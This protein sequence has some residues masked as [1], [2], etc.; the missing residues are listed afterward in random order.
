LTF[1]AMDTIQ[2]NTFSPPMQDST[3]SFDALHAAR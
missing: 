2:G 1:P 3:S